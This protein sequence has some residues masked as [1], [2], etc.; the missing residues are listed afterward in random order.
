V[1][2]SIKSP[3]ILFLQRKYTEAIQVLERVCLIDPEDIQMHYTLMLCY[4]GIGDS[5]KA[6]REEKLFSRFKADEAAQ[7]I[8]G[9]R[10]LQS[11][12][13]NNERQPI[14]EH[15]TAPFN[16]AE[17]SNEIR[18]SSIC[19]LSDSHTRQTGR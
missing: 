7:S 5:D 19:R 16:S 8:T 17:D 9:A 14:H 1:S 10:R 2:C 15:E 12:E 11:P 3:E 4:R 13:D 18:S 6:A